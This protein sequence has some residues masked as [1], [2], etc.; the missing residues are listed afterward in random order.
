MSRETFLVGAHLTE[1]SVCTCR[2]ERCA[3]GWSDSETSGQHPVDALSGVN[4]DCAGTGS[5]IAGRGG[6]AA[7]K[8]RRQ[9]RRRVAMRRR[10]RSRG[11]RGLVGGARAM[12]L[13]KRGES[14]RCVEA[15]N[16]RQT[17]TGRALD[18]DVSSLNDPVRY[19]PMRVAR[20]GW[21]GRILLSRIS[22]P[23]PLRWRRHVRRAVRCARRYGAVVLLALS[24]CGFAAF[25]RVL[26][27]S[28]RKRGEWDRGGLAA[29][30]FRNHL[31]ACRSSA[32]VARRRT[33]TARWRITNTERGRLRL[34]FRL[35]IGHRECGR[36]GPSH[37]HRNSILSRSS[38]RSGVR[39]LRVSTKRAS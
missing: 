3:R 29:A 24:R 11:Q 1:D 4:V 26:A 2:G 16:A 37:R 22:W 28:S 17:G 23:L 8:W 9:R 30:R 35:R 10:K 6:I 39:F 19:S 12:L 5:G 18:E 21:G 25:V 31:T 15:A 32:E 36:L 34:A 33:L 20:T 27:A 7:R 38:A 14:G 13:H